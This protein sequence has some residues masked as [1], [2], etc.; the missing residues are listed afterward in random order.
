[1]VRRLG[2]VAVV[3]AVAVAGLAPGAAAHPADAQPVQ[4]AQPADIQAVQAAGGFVDVTGGVHKPAID[5]LAERGLF[6]GT[7]CGEDMFCPGDEMKRWTM[8]VWLVRVLDEAEP[9]AATESS[10]A[11]VD[12]GNRWLA[13]I[14]RLAELEI[15]QGCLVDPL[16]FC[17]DRS[18]NRAEMATFLERAFDLEAADPAGF[19]D[20]A[21][22]FHEANIDALAAARITAGCQSDPPRYCPDQPVTRAEMATFLARALGLVEI[23]EPAPEPADDDTDDAEDDDADA[24]ATEED[25]SEPATLIT[26]VVTGGYHSCALLSYGAILC[27][28]DDYYGQSVRAEGPFSAVTA[29]TFHTCGIRTD[30]TVRCWGSNNDSQDEYAG[31]ADAPDGTF[32]AVSAGNEHTCGIR[33]DGTVECWGNNNYGQSSALEGGF[34]AVD[35]GIWHTCGVRTDGTVECWGDDT[36]G[37]SSAP[38]GGFTAVT[39]AWGHSCGLRTDGTVN[40]WGN[41]QHGQATAPDGTFSTVDVGALH[42]CG[43]RTGGTV[44][45]WGFNDH[46]Q[47]NGPGRFSTI[48]LG[49]SVCRPHG[50]PYHTA[51]FPLPDWAVPSIGTMRVA[52]LFIDFPDAVATH[53]TE[54]EAALGLPY[55]EAYLEAVSYGQLDVEFVALHRWLRA[56]NN[57]DHYA[58]P[59]AL[60][61]ARVVIDSEAV[62]LADP[63]FDFTG[64]HAAMTVLPSSL[65]AGGENNFAG[66]RTD[67]GPVGPVSRVNN[68]AIDEPREPVRWGDVAA[69]ELM[70]GL[71]L[72]D[73]YPYDGSVHQL[74]EPSG[75]EVVVR[76]DF[77][78]MGLTAVF[79]ARA[80]D[81]RH[82]IDWVYPNGSTTTSYTETLKAAEMLAWSRWQLGWLDESQ[83]RCIDT[84][85]ARVRLSPVADPGAGVAMA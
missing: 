1:M 66:L 44:E 9:A 10:F 68:A 8:A 62:R 82:R 22:N 55:A 43:I 28:G 39:A 20:T 53:S 80:A 73:H 17:P 14:E 51:G 41:N 69:H 35:A 54:V 60:G 33:T 79:R 45:C 2:V 74:P 6:E 3:V 70:H 46:G 15:T 32:T 34:T 4:P 64:F 47:T 85:N 21:G 63:S 18:V 24:E 59:G 76:S 7:E 42:S 57:Y 72:T 49:S 71:G 27:W 40:C 84:P 48:E 56:E 58:Q 52:V 78:L 23:P 5:A 50:T 29:G 67:E 30:G 38:E 26:T 19:A 65:F 11:D 61:D 31:Q 12:A 25:G 83:V 16:R 81:R 13:H 36:L 77:G 75:S 37:Q